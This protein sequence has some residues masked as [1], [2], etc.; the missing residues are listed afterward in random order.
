MNTC[1]KLAAIMGCAL[2]PTLLLSMSA[3]AA[4]APAHTT[5][6]QGIWQKH[7]YLLAYMGFTTTYSCDGLA[8]KVK[9]LLLAAGAR[10]DAK[11]RSAACASG[12]GHPDKFARAELTFYTLGPAAGVAPSD[13]KPI[14]AV[15]RPVSFAYR[16]PREL[17]TGD[18]ELIEQ[19]RD[20]VLPMFT[21]RN[22]DNHTTCVPH[23]ES[24]S[25]ISLHFEALAA[26]PTGPAALTQ[27][28]GS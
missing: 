11:S 24:G 14:D 19:F 6:E 22:I 18:C 4:D 16:S 12:F 23:Q 7:E 25:S 27:A 1:R 26:A 28:G 20:N 5:Q 15:W 9:V 21:T 17:T 2:S 10:H 3:S 13:S 8:D